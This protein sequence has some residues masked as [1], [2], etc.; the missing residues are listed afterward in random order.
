MNSLHM[1]CFC[2][3]FQNWHSPPLLGVSAGLSIAQEACTDHSL[4]KNGDAKESFLPVDLGLLILA[5]GSS[6]L[7]SVAGLRE[8]EGDI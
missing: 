5:Q 3:Y 1:S 8:L 6:A 2:Y 4:G 7:Q